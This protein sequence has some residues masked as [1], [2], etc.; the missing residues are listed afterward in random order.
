MTTIRI[1]RGVPGRRLV[2]RWST[3]L[4][5]A[6]LNLLLVGLLFVGLVTR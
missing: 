4:A 1:G 2:P 5:E 3:W 6:G